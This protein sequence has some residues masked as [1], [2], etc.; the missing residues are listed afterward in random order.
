[1]PTLIPITEFDWPGHPDGGAADEESET[2][3]QAR[4]DGSL[5]WHAYINDAEADYSFDDWALMR[6][7]DGRWAVLNTRGCSCPS[8][9]EEWGVYVLGTAEEVC[10]WIVG[11]VGGARYGM[12]L[13][14]GKEFEAWIDL[15]RAYRPDKIEPEPA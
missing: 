3:R 13:L 12:G 15:I 2:I 1:M 5:E 14:Q 10:D 9:R 6:L 8:P 4:S 11:F 7:A